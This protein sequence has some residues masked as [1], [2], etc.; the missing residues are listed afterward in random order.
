MSDLI[1]ATDVLEVLLAGAPVE[2]LEAHLQQL[3]FQER[4]TALCTACYMLDEVKATCLERAEGIADI[5]ER[6]C[7]FFRSGVRTCYQSGDESLVG[8]PKPTSATTGE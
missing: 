3:E 6:N 7:R 4:Q 1:T 5:L 8:F 2:E